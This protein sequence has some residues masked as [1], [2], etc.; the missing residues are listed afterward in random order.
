MIPNYY[1]EYNN[2]VNEL[3]EFIS[4]ENCT[5]IRVLIN[6][7][8][9]R[10]ILFKS[11]SLK[12]IWNFKHVKLEIQR[13][14]SAKF[15]QKFPGV[16]ARQ[17]VSE[18]SQR[19]KRFNFV[20]RPRNCGLYNG[21]RLS[22]LHRGTSTCIYNVVSAGGVWNFEKLKISGSSVFRGTFMLQVYSTRYYLDKTDVRNNQTSACV[23]KRAE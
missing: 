12:S 22:A 10:E 14:L 23:N 8:W 9:S 19:R 21:A 5:A 4:S 16:N 20:R 13:N 6:T 11:P 1:C 18:F 3:N 2:E 15:L 17:Q 7:R